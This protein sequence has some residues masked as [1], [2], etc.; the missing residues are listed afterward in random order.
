MKNKLFFWWNQEWNQEIRGVSEAACVPTAAEQD[1][2][3]SQGCQL[4]RDGT[5]ASRYSFPAV[6]TGKS[7]QDRSIRIRRALLYRAVLSRSQ[8]RRAAERQ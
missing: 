4:R 5:G 1:G 2:D 7:A 3:F 6:P 8:R